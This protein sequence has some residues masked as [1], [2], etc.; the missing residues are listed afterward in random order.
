MKPLAKIL[1]LFNAFWVVG[2]RDQTATITPK[3][4]IDKFIS[5]NLYNWTWCYPVDTSGW[6]NE[7]GRKYALQNEGYLK[8]LDAD[9]IS[10]S[11]F[12][13]DGGNFICLAPKAV[14]SNDFVLIPITKNESIN[15]A[16]YQWRSS[17]Q[18]CLIPDFHLNEDFF[19]LEQYI[20]RQRDTSSVKFKSDMYTLFSL[21][22]SG[23]YQVDLFEVQKKINI[24][25]ENG[26]ELIFKDDLR[27][28]KI[29][30]DNLLFSF[31]Y[32]AIDGYHIFLLRRSSDFSF[33]KQHPFRIQYLI[34]WPSIYKK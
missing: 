31:V 34:V 9:I 6:A 12:C 26:F 14:D 18:D 10:I 24:A 11:T 19:S 13:K 16:I 30:K 32:E 4:S 21:Y 15:G 7:P 3:V 2:C 5:D 17:G 28:K 27:K 23:K 33:N 29:I 22:L 8:T 20:N 25:K 1:I